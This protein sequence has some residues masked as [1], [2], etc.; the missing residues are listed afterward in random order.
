MQNHYNALW[1]ED[2]RE[3]IPFCRAEGLGLVPYSPLGRGFLC[4]GTTTRRQKDE[5]IQRFYPRSEDVAVAAAVEAH[6]RAHGATP[7][8]VALGWVLTT[9]GVT[10]T[11]IG[12]SSVEQLE[13]AISYADKPLDRAAM[14]AIDAAYAFR[15][16]KGHGG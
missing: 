16:S 5:M 9:P 4:G 7:A 10:A 15:P 12:A 1:R 6:A 2:E 8:A 14:G 3:L 13:Q 11:V